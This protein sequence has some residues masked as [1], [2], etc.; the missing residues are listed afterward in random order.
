MRKLI[1]KRRDFEM[2]NN[3]ACPEVLCLIG[4]GTP[5]MLR[6]SHPLLTST[7]AMKTLIG[8]QIGGIGDKRPLI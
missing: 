5:N 8:S 1:W 2:V 4:L 6:P 3:A 7:P